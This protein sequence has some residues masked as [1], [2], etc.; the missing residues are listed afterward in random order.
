ML[1]SHISEKGYICKTY[2]E[3]LKLKIKSKEPNQKMNKFEETLH[4]RKHTNGKSVVC[5]KM[6]NI[7]N[8]WV[9]AN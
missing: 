8:H 6:V 1:T 7:I 9:N 3:L 5:E 4:Q 2:K